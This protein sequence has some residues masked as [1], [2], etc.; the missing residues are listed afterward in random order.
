MYILYKNLKMKRVNKRLAFS[1]QNLLWAF[2]IPVYAN[3]TKM[4][5]FVIFTKQMIIQL[6][7]MTLFFSK[8]I[9]RT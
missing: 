3:T 5:M 4:L 8:G 9:F 1:M 6:T 7:V 2:K